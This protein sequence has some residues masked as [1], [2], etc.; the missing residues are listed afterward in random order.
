[1]IS[2]SVFT[3]DIYIFLVGKQIFIARFT[4]NTTALWIED[5]SS[6]LNLSIIYKLKNIPIGI[7]TLTLFSKCHL[8][9][10]YILAILMNK[11]LDSQK[12]Q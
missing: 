9:R 12:R 10:Y 8:V 3:E 2:F 4:E 6:S 5:S 1:M 7:G 11:S